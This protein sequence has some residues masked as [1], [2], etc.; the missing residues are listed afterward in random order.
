MTPIDCRLDDRLLH[1]QVVENWIEILR[2]DL[3]LVANDRVA[4]DPFTRELY[5][6]ALPPAVALAVEPLACAA[7]RLRA[8]AGRVLLIAG[9]AADAL[10]LV[11]EGIGVDRIVVGGLHHAPGKERVLD[12][13]Y[14]DAADRAALRALAAA[15]IA[16]VA[17]D[18]PSRRPTD[19]T[20]LLGPAP[21]RRDV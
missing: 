12:F 18:V 9:S 15:G 8:A 17:Q 10:A 6:A 20:P 2:P 1:G 11:R 21:A 7:A 19:L 14:L 13:V 3:I 16:L 5:A 4:G